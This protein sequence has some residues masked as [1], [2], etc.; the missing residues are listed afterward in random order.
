MKH[1]RPV[2]VLT[3]LVRTVRSVGR[4]RRRSGTR[5]PGDKGPGVLDERLLRRAAEVN[6]ALAWEFHRPVGQPRANPA[7]RRMEAL[8]VEACALA[9][10]A[11]ERARWIHL[12]VAEEQ[13]EPPRGRSGN[14]DLV[15]VALA[16]AWAYGALTVL[17]AQALSR[18]AR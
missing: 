7:I 5:P 10:V 16:V 3:P 12:D 14:E 2:G 8:G 6:E 17:R 15:R 1:S 18:Q 4:E 9:R 13:A 11:L